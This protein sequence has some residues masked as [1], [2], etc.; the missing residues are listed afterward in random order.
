MW[1]TSVQ[2]D[3]SNIKKPLEESE[4]KVVMEDFDKALVEVKPHLGLQVETLDAFMQ[5]GIVDYGERFDKLQHTLGKLAEQ[6]RHS[7]YS[8]VQLV[9]Y[10]VVKQLDSDD[11]IH[12]HKGLGGRVALPILITAAQLCHL[13][14]GTGKCSFWWVCQSCS[15]AQS[16][17]NCHT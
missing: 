7:A 17:D 12:A 11:G 4:I 1:A 2:V 15:E 6:V 16:C 14:H 3:V 8:Y 9:V 13:R 5:H 10:S